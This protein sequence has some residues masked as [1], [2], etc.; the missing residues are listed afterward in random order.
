[1]GLNTFGVLRDCE[2]RLP[3]RARYRGSEPSSGK[4]Q[5]DK[6]VNMDFAP[7]TPT[8]GYERYI[9]ESESTDG[10][11]DVSGGQQRREPK[12][13]GHRLDKD[14]HH[15]PSSGYQHGKASSS[16]SSSSSIFSRLA[17]SWKKGS[18]SATR[19]E[20]PPGNGM[21]GYH[22]HG[23]KHSGLAAAVP[24]P[25]AGD[26]G[27]GGGAV[28]RDIREGSPRAGDGGDDGSGRSFGVG[29]GGSRCVGRARH[30]LNFSQSRTYA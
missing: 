19:T 8:A 29:V 15:A 9:S 22:H 2:R 25:G 27:G 21:T 28:W 20:E 23:N 24:E 26:G 12:V 6:A 17:A 16:S 3:L 1:M 7:D 5:S 11:G 14:Q 30:F 18:E 13:S 4:R 10:E